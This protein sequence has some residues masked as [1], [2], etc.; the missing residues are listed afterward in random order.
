MGALSIVTIAPELLAFKDIVL[1]QRAVEVP[2]QDAE[3]LEICQKLALEMFEV[4][5]VTDGV[6][7][8][9]PQVGISL[10][11][12]VM[13]PGDSDFGP[14]T[15]IN[16]VIEF[17]SEVE[18]AR[19]EACL[20]VPRYAGR[21]FRSTEVHV[22]AY[23]LKGE[24]EEYHATEWL[25][26]I[27]QHEIDHLNGILYPDQLRPGDSL[28]DAELAVRDRAAAAVEKSLE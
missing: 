20:S 11:L 19:A 4:M 24:P 12:V 7:L 10:R 15:L 22:R 14:H 13:D 3:F 17:K 27:F 28:F 2:V 1:R 21:V 18:E 26:R 23:N 9:A 5:Y 16:P 25:A 8:A 6:G